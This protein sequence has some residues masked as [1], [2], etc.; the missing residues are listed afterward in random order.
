MRYDALI[1][2]GLGYVQHSREETQALIPVV[3]RALQT[4]QRLNLQ[5]S[6]ILAVGDDLSRSHD[7]RGRGRPTGASLR[8]SGTQSFQLPAGSCTAPQGGYVSITTKT[9]TDYDPK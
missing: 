7:H 1:V 8:G 9:I 3:G 6:A 2:D 4:R 5:S